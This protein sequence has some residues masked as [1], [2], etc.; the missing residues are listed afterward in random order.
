MEKTRNKWVELGNRF[1]DGQTAFLDDMSNKPAWDKMFI[2]CNQTCELK[3]AQRLRRT[4][5]IMEH[6]LF[7]DTALEAAVRIM[8]RYKKPKGYFV[9][10]LANV[11]EFSIKDVLDSKKAMFEND[12]IPNGLELDEIMGEAATLLEVYIDE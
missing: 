4:G 9:K 5:F 2:A 6:E 3:L 11:C 8:N 12:V 10:N 7:L 1:K